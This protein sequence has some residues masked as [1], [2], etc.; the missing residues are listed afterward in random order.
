MEQ[1]S[2]DYAGDP[3]LVLE[4]SYSNSLLKFENVS[5]TYSSDN[6]ALAYFEEKDGNTIF[7]VNEVE[8]VSAKITVTATYGETT[9]TDTITV[10]YF[11]ATKGA[12][13]VKEAIDATVDTTMRIRGVVS[14]KICNKVGFY[15]TDSTGS[16]ACLVSKEDL[17]TVSVGD[18]IVLEGTRT[19]AGKTD[20]K[21]G[22]KTITQ[23]QMTSCNVIGVITQGNAYSTAAIESSTIHD[24]MEKKTKEDTAKLYTTSAYIVL[25][26]S[27]YS[28]Q[29]YLFASKEDFDKGKE[30][31]YY[32]GDCMRVYNN[33]EKDYAFLLPFVGKQVTVE[34]AIVNFNGNSYLANPISVDDGTTKVYSKIS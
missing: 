16:I 23:I 20:K 26:S 30:G 31:K 7:H 18:E 9:A 14:G 32:I 6:E 19:E 10:H 24:L 11:D 15:V 27:G 13:K 8:Q 4:K 5:F 34:M 2:N 1:F 21:T 33:G 17:E 12:K 3:N 29:P 28:P 25:D 22:I